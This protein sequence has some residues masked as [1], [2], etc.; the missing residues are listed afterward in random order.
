MA[1]TLRLPAKTEEHR[2]NISA[3]II[4]GNLGKG[5]KK[6]GD[7]KWL[8]S[9]SEVK[10]FIVDE[11][12]TPRVNSSDAGERKLAIWITSNKGNKVPS[13]RNNERKQLMRMEIPRILITLHL[14]LCQT[15][16]PGSAT[17]E[18]TPRLGEILDAT[19]LDGCNY[20]LSLFSTN[21]PTMRKQLME[22]ASSFRSLKGVGRGES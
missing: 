11:G 10:T 18:T 7:D 14:E 6:S 22:E 1:S 4:A 16:I 2:A 5:K 9:L 19:R 15:K 13:K 12:R 3:G 8:A 20:R 17:I 21:Q